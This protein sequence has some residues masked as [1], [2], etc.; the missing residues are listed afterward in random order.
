VVV[1][2]F[3]NAVAVAGGSV[4][5][6]VALRR[7]GDTA[8]MSFSDNGPGIAGENLARVFEPYFT[9]RAEGSGLGLAML[10]NIV[11]MHGGTVDV[12]SAPGRGATF[13]VRLPIAGPPE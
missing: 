9:T 7:D 11:L 3:D 10:K 1:N 12:E 13:T 8:V 4:A 5:V 6:G 2:L